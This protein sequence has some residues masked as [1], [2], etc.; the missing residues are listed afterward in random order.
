MRTFIILITLLFAIPS[1]GAEF[2]V[3][4]TDKGSAEEGYK[5]GD[6]VEVFD[7]GR[8]QP[9]FMD[10][11][12]VLIRVPGLAADRTK[13]HSWHM[14]LDYEVITSNASGKRIRV[15]AVNKRASDA[16]GELT[17]AQ[18]ENFIIKHGGKVESVSRN[19]VVF[20]IA[21]E[22]IAQLKEDILIYVESKPIRRRMWRI[23]EAAV[24]AAEAGNGVA[25]FTTT[26]AINYLTKKAD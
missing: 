26:Q 12:F 2:L 6:I 10:V 3:M 24:A 13:Q 15:W 21:H 20:D 14:V 1:F 17:R 4:T 25:T 22:D 23:P 7:D 9:Q 8:L 18:V 19:E 16:L 11:P 5:R